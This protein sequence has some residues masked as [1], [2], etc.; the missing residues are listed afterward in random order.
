MTHIQKY[1][2]ETEYV[3]QIGEQTDG[4]EDLSCLSDK[5]IAWLESC[6]VDV[7]KA[8]RQG[9]LWSLLNNAV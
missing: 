5:G 3:I 9:L 7:R 6:A 8:Y 2:D 4:F 1:A